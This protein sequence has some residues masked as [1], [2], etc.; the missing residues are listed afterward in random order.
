VQKPVT[1]IV[2]AIVAEL[3]ARIFTPPDPASHFVLWLGILCIAIP[4]YIAGL[5]QGRARARTLSSLER[6]VT[7][8]ESSNRN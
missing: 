8:V 2:I 4:S 3:L 5:K 7:H 1:L 6:A